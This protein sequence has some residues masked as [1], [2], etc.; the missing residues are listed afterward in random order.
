MAALIGMASNLQ[1]ILAAHV[2]FQFVDR[3]RLCPAHNVQRHGLMSV[4]A[5]TADLKVEI[6]GVEGVAERQG[7]LGWAFVSEHA[8]IP[9]LAGEPVS[10]VAR[11]AR[12]AEARMEAP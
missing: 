12:S 5:E 7:R 1:T 9:S 10:F 4:A 6:S 3:G 11:L 8:L 2:A